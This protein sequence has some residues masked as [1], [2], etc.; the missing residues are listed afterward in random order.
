M[1][2]SSIYS[3][4]E[5]IHHELLLFAAFWFL[6]GALDDN[7]IDI[8]WIARTIY[9]KFTVF[10]KLKPVCSTDLAYSINAGRLAI[11]VP[12]W[13]EAGV[14]KHMLRRCAD[15]WEH[16][17]FRIYVGCYPNDPATAK[18]VI[19]AATKSSNI[20][21]I[22][23]PTNGPT[24]KADCLNRLWRAMTED[25]YIEDI[26]TKA[27]IL[28]DAED[29][30]HADELRIF[31]RLMDTNDLVQLPVIP[32]QNPNSRWVSGHYCDEFSEA[33]GKQ[34]VA[35]EALGASIP[36]AGVG[37]AFS[38][39]A[40]AKFADFSDGNP[41]DRDSLTEDYEI[42]LKIAQNGG[43]SIFVRMLDREGQIAG[44][45]EFFPSTV[46]SSVRQKSRWMIGI[47]LAGWDR[48]G[49]HGGFAERWMRMRDRRATFSA[50]VLA[51][52]YLTILLWGVLFVSQKLSLHEPTPLSA[53]VMF[54]LRLNLSFLIWRLLLRAAFVWNSYGFVE[55]LYSIPRSLVSI[56]IAVIAARRAIAKYIRTLRGAEVSWDKTSHDFPH[57][58]VQL[59]NENHD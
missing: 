47:A 2:L 55:A 42:G 9:R 25:E 45:Q 43:R 29:V 8:F 39:S 4:I 54:L 57:Q 14:V 37:C 49:W 44:T 38:R 36:S 32:L 26:Q 23:M 50:V 27:V 19:E 33:H 21:V 18:D 34:L 59:G 10:R 15:V 46:E 11:F 40:L 31:D 51:A 7:S 12:A 35:R 20:R 1:D 53:E 3:V 13:D 41:F 52:A 28:H 22:L 6:I 17:N 56:T 16:P 48:M 30:V 5:A 24:T 58:Y